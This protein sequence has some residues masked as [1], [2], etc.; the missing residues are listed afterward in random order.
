VCWPD[1]EFTSSEQATLEC[2]ASLLNTTPEDLGRGAW[3]G[4]VVYFLRKFAKAMTPRRLAHLLAVPL[5]SVGTALT[6]TGGVA[7]LMAEFGISGDTVVAILQ[8][9]PLCP[10]VGKA[11]SG[12]SR[13]GARAKPWQHPGR[14][15]SQQTMS[16]VHD[17]TFGSAL[18]SHIVLSA[19]AYPQCGCRDT[20]SCRVVDRAAV[21]SGS[22][23]H[24]HRWRAR[25]ARRMCVCVFTVV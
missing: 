21:A 18:Y 7:A 15:P 1:G 2:L 23:A 13:H 19:G 16:L 22:V 6:F 11:S 3:V 10:Q 12:W 25:R 4:C 24:W 20:A 17:L 9:L 8:T 14:A 5:L